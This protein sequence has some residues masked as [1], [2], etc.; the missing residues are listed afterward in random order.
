DLNDMEEMTF[1]RTYARN[2]LRNKKAIR[3]LEDTE[4]LSEQDEEGEPGE[5]VAF[6]TVSCKKDYDRIREK[7]TEIL[8]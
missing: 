4:F 8:N 3:L 5:R 7:L 6:V 1:F 2:I